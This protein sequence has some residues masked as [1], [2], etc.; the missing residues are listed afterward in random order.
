[1]TPFEFL[2]L[3]VLNSISQGCD[4]SIRER[5]L[6]EGIDPE[7]EL[8]TYVRA[9]NLCTQNRPNDLTIGLHMCR[10]NWPSGIGVCSFRLTDRSK[11][12]KL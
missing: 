12:S 8:Q 2:R 7:T 10:G 4:E 5:S 6:A 3:P 11:L 1:M 9:I